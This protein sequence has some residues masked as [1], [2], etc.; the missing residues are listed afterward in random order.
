MTDNLLVPN[1]GFKLYRDKAIWVG[2]FIGGPLVA[3]YLI[4]SN[5]KKLGEDKNA[6]KC[7]GYALGSTMILLAIAILISLLASSC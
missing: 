4:A 2:T 3:G 1:K 7:W 6:M 5:Y